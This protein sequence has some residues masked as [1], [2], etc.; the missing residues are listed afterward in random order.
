MKKEHISSKKFRD[1]V[2]EMHERDVRDGEYFDNKTYYRAM[3]ILLSFVKNRPLYKVERNLLEDSTEFMR[4]V[5]FCVSVVDKYGLSFD[6]RN[7]VEYV[8][9]FIRDNDLIHKY[10]LNNALISAINSIDIPYYQL[11]K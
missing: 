4:S 9:T 2:Q 7:F 1:K 10:H 11:V 5:F 3:N 8:N 6:M